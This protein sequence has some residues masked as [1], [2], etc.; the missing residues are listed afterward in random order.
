M[1]SSAVAS[2]ESLCLTSSTASAQ[3]CRKNAQARDVQKSSAVALSARRCCCRTQAYHQRLMEVPRS[4]RE[5]ISI[6]MAWC[7]S[8]TSKSA[9]LQAQCAKPLRREALRTTS[10]ER[11]SASSRSAQCTHH[12]ARSRRARRL[13]EASNASAMREIPTRM[14]WL[15]FA[16]WRQCAKT[17]LRRWTL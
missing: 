4:A 8:D 12:N 10:T 2:R 16:A 14:T 7:C 15:R 5:R 13:P 17:L 1:F 11:C 3:T 6:A 9:T